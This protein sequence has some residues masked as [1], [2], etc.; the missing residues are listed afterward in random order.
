MKGILIFTRT[1]FDPSSATTHTSSIGP[2]KIRHICTAQKVPHEVSLTATSHDPSLS[3]KAASTAPESHLGNLWPLIQEIHRH[4]APR[5]AYRRCASLPVDTWKRDARA[6]LES[7]LNFAP[8]KCALDLELLNVVQRPGYERR[9][10]RF[11]TTPYTRVPGYLLVP[12]VGKPPYPAVLA[13]HDHGGFFYYGKEKLVEIPAEHEALTQFRERYYGGL[14]VADELAQRGYVVLVI[15]AFYWG[16][17]RLQFTAT[18]SELAR[19]VKDLDPADPEYVLATN[20]FL[21][22]RTRSLNTMLACAGTTWLGMLVH[23]D[24]RSLDLL[25]GLPEVD[26]DRLGV[27]GLSIGGYRTTYLA[28]IDPRVKAACIVGW[29]TVLHTCAAIRHVVHADIPMA[30]GLHAYLDHPDVASLGA[31]ECALFVLQC[32]A[33]QL[34]TWEGM[35]E[36]AAQIENVYAHLGHPERYRAQFFDVPHRFDAAMQQEAYGWFDRWLM[37]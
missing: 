16:E 10:I 32:A 21:G 28:G 20:R 34:F 25:A 1:D 29:M 33:D 12:T 15:D 27:V 37:R 4:Q 19:R 22:E 36:A 13:L 14:S 17:R 9:A 3:G 30:A 6:V 7:C 26:K 31:P 35:R 11:S 23:D 5:L 24:R 2:C 8:P 18:D